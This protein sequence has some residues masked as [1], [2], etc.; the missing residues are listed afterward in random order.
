MNRLN[1]AVFGKRF[2][3]HG[4]RLRVIPVIERSSTGR[5][6]YHLVL[7]NPYPDT[8]ELFERLIETEWRKTPFGYFETH[9]HQQIDHGW[10]DYISKTKT[11]SDGIDWATY[12]WN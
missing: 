1:Y 11:A 3:R 4:V 9:V 10:T 12:H 6:H 8:P 2:Q 7:Q 5:L